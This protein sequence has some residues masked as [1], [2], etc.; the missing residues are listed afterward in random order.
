MSDTRIDL[1]ETGVLIERL[2]VPRKDVADFL[3]HIPE[4]E[5][6]SRLVQA[7]EV[8]VFCL[9]RAQTSR[10]LDFVKRQVESLLTSVGAAVEK[11]PDTTQRSL[12][13]KM[14]TGDGQVLAPVKSLIGDV[15]KTVS[16]KIKELSQLLTEEIDP[17][18]ESTTL[19]R[20]LRSLRELLDPIRTD[21]I[22]GVL[23]A[24]LTEVTA[25]DGT[26]AKAVKEAVAEAVKPLT[27]RVDSLARE[28]HGQEAAAEALAQTTEKGTPYETEVLGRLQTWSKTIGAEIRHVGGDNRPGDILVSVVAAED[29]SLF[30][31]VVEVRDR[32]S[33]KGR[34]AVTDDLSA[35]MAERNAGYAIY[36]SRNR[37]GLGQELGEWAEG[38]CDRGPWV[39]CTDEHLGTAV[40]FLLVQ[41]AIARRRAATPTIDAA[42]ATAQIERI[43]T[44][45]ARVKN[46]NTKTTAV[47][48]SATDIQ[49]EAESLRDDV[50]GA[51]SDLEVALSLRSASTSESA[52]P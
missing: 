14:G 12:L 33:P 1:R 23:A 20:T 46:I 11:I 41:W 7:I 24:K 40:R 39:A 51:L 47:R 13:E 22:Q 15:S 19:G 32:Q 50:R 2:E 5:R 52:G 34:K 10:D 29:L 35:A 45:L 44:A 37:D 4:A 48:A 25:G 17:R 38:I 30:N 21:S 28:V 43:R 3:S 8:G 42:A 31:L 16:D 26:L 49:E 27:E 9:E 36:L 18:K 6:E